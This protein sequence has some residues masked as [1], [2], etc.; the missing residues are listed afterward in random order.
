MQVLGSIL[1]VTAMMTVAFY[2]DDKEEVENGKQT[3]F[4]IRLF[5]RRI[6]GNFYDYTRKIEDI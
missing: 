5:G 4:K 2:L 3:S 1:A 6:I